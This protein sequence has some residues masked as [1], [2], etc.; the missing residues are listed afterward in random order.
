MNFWK[1]FR[2]D[3]AVPLDGTERIYAIGDIH[4]RL[5]LLQH[6]VHLIERDLGNFTRPSVRLIFL[7]DFIDRG[8]HSQTLVDLLMR[9]DVNPRVTILKGNHEA[10]LVDAYRGDQDALAGWLE[11]GGF[12]TLA[13]YGVDVGVFAADDLRTVYRCLCKT[14]PEPTIRWLDGLPLT[15]VS[16]GHL[17]VHAGIRPGVDLSEQAPDDL[18]WIRGDFTRSDAD[19]GMI[20][21]HGHTVYETGV[22]IAPNRIGVDTGAWRTGILSALIVE[23]G[24]PYRTLAT[25][26]LK[27][28]EHGAPG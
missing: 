28:Y 9:L 25:S 7:G 1:M 4:G 16:N 15:E 3:P 27:Q 10:A 26:K 5:D 21:V 11:H 12:A 23:E 19:H 22:H 17:F 8:P 18:L 13:S 6:L 14:I 20:V 24:K 2:K